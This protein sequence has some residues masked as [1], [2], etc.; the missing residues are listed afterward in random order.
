MLPSWEKMNIGLP[1]F[2][3][4]L[5]AA[6]SEAAHGTRRQASVSLSRTRGA[7]VSTQASSR[8]AAS[9]GSARAIAQGSIHRFIVRPPCGDEGEIIARP[10]AAVPGEQGRRRNER[11]GAD[12]RRGPGGAS[13][14]AGAGTAQLRRDV[15]GG[16]AAAGRPGR[17]VPRR[18]DG[19]VDRR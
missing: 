14:G 4:A 13:G 12:S 1:S 2:F 11:D 19:A 10:R 6:V 5:A 9:A 15:T 18:G 7:S 17:L 8:S 3:A 16:A